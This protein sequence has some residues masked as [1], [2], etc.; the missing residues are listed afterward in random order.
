MPSGQ[1]SL[2]GPITLL[3]NV[4]LFLETRA[5]LRFRTDAPELYL[6][7][8]LTRWE[9]TELFNY[10]PFIY[11][12]QANRVA[13]TG[14]GLIDGNAHD[15]FVTWR[16]R[17]K[18][19]QQ[20]LRKLGADGAPVASRLFGAGHWLR[21]P[22]VQFFGCA[23][24]LLDGP[25]FIDSPFWVNHAVGCNNVT[26]RRIQ[27]DSPHLNSDG[28]DPES[29]TDVL[30]EDCVFK[31]GDDCIAI[32]SGRDQDG[33]RTGRPTENVV[34][35]RCEMHAPTAGSGLAIGSEMSG[36]VRN[37][38]AESLRMGAAKIALNIKAN[39][40]R[41]GAVENISVRDVSVESTD[42]LVQ[43]TTDYHG[44]R[45]GDFPP[46]FRGFTFENL[47]CSQSP[48]PLSA[49]GRPTSRIEDLTLRNLRIDG[50]T[51]PAAIRHARNVV[52]EQV[53]VNGQSWNS[54]RDVD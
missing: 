28:F 29:C 13:I 35:R 30:I 34:I 5:H 24:V 33:W 6:P 37:V 51:T 2:A 40:D 32:K 38:Y 44:Y 23:N 21:P 47:R 50:A 53:L 18:E 4:H 17:Q 52:T 19:A 45:G 20:A 27:V 22:L 39:L 15:T 1:W 16:P 11:A 46:R 7:A 25:R 41:G 26:V 54:P 49:I 43:V 10:S 9:G 12:Y 42:L 3:S 14:D 31:T 8:V 48:T 36:G